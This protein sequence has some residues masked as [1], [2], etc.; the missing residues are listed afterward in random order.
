MA[1]NP[2]QAEFCVEGGGG[3]RV[4]HAFK[5]NQVG[6]ANAQVG[7]LVEQRGGWLRSRVPQLERFSVRV[8]ES[9]QP[10]LLYAPIIIF[11]M[12]CITVLFAPFHDHALPSYA[13]Y[14]RILI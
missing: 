6:G 5:V 7:R 10:G 3:T 12:Q 11:L 2:Q 1:T 14:V 4:E 13:C 8:T 9:I